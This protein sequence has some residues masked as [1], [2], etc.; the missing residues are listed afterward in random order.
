MPFGYIGQNQTKQ[1]IKNSGIL[2]SFEVSHLEKLGQAGGS[3]ELIEEVNITSDTAQIDFT[4]IK[5]NKYDVHLIQFENFK[6]TT[7]G[8]DARIRF[9]ESG[10]LESASVYQYAHQLNQTSQNLEQRSTGIAYIRAGVGTGNNTGERSNGYVYFYNLGNS[11]KYSF[12]TYHSVNLNTTS[13]FGA[14]FGGAVLPQASQVD[15][16]R[17]YAD[18]GITTVTAKLYGVKQI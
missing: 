9:F 17:F 4:S 13:T 11:A 16:I 1:K 8:K 3:L 10:V 5:E 15:G 7:D 18:G 14:T 2:S 6:S 12:V